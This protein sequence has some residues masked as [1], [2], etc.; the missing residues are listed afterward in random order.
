MLEILA[1][2]FMQ[3][4]LI[5]GIA[6]GA[7]CSILGLFLVL[8]RYSLFGD[9]LAHV[10]LSGVAIGLF[11]NIYPLWTAL[12]TSV[13]ASLGI[14]R[15]RQSI[16]MQGDALIAVLLI[17]GVAVAVLLISASGGF[18]VDL[19]SYLFGSITLISNEDM[20][21]AVVASIAILASVMAL[22]DKLF[23]MALD[24]RQAKISGLNIALLNYIFMIMASIMVI[25][26]MRLVGILLV[27]SLIVI[28]NIAAMMLGRGFK[29]TMLISLCI[30][31]TSV[32]VGIITSY[33][34]N[35]ATSGMIVVVCIGIMASIMLSKH[36]KIPITMR[37]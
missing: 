30:S 21:T 15:L 3:K 7:A 29:A 18:K 8:R 1:Y 13:T 9:A 14:T 37:R 12:L 5:A 26:A 32:I 20:L 22:K 19:F 27:S 28:P 25:V 23:Y 31:L 6:I 10:A 17:F 24:E 34:L 36:L 16:R 33:Y 4:A 2:T 35:V 11:F